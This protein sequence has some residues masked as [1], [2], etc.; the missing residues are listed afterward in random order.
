MDGAANRGDTETV[1]RFL[2]IIEQT[3]ADRGVTFRKAAECGKLKSCEII[4][5]AQGSSCLL[6]IDEDGNSALH[7]A[8]VNGHLDVVK[9]LT[10][11]QPPDK[12]INKRHQLP[13]HLAAEAGH[14]D[15]AQFLVSCDNAIAN[16][17]DTANM[18]PLHHAA[19]HNRV[20]VVKCLMDMGADACI[21]DSLGRNALDVAIDN[22]CFKVGQAI[23][24]N[25]L[26]WRWVL[27]NDIEPRD[28]SDLTTDQLQ[29]L[30]YDDVDKVYNSTYRETP[31]R[32]M[33]RKLPQLAITVFDKCAPDKIGNVEFIDDTYASWKSTGK[34]NSE[35]QEKVRLVVCFALLY[36][37]IHASLFLLRL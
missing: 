34:E 25:A 24:Q 30:G 11:Y 9:L 33:I 27:M 8:A 14:L 10:I 15:V 6:S 4:G 5:T 37:G 29:L 1:R 19:K 16:F 18:T 28:L 31:L 7:L 20:D 35:G 17:K 21:R 26:Q 23:L 3:S 22:G 2:R 13:V 36:H 12:N 32:R